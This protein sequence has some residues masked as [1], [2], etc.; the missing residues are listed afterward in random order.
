LIATNC[1]KSILSSASDSNSKNDSHTINIPAYRALWPGVPPP[2]Q[3]IRWHAN[4]VVVVQKT[5]S[6]PTITMADDSNR[7]DGQLDDASG[8]SPLIRY[9]QGDQIDE[10]KD[11]IKRALDNNSFNCQ[12]L[13]NLAKSGAEAASLVKELIHLNLVDQAELADRI[14]K[15]IVRD[16][17]YHADEHLKQYQKYTL[18]APQLATDI[19]KYKSKFFNLISL[20]KDVSTLA[21]KLLEISPRFESFKPNTPI[22]SSAIATDKKYLLNC[23]QRDTKSQM[24]EE[25]ATSEDLLAALIESSSS[26]DFLILSSSLDSISL[27]DMLVAS[28]ILITSHECFTLSHDIQGVAM[29]LRRAKFMIKN[30][31]A[32]KNQMELIIRLLT[33][34]GRY[35]EMKYVFDL[36]RDRNQFEILLSKG[37]EKT[38]ELRIAMFNYVKKNPEFYAL[39]TLNFSMFR[40]IA[41]SLEA[42]A[43]KRLDK[44]IDQSRRKSKRK[45]SSLM[46]GGIGSGA[47]QQ[48]RANRD[49]DG[50]EPFPSKASM[51]K[52]NSIGANLS[53]MVNGGGDGISPNNPSGSKG[54]AEPSNTKP[55]YSKDSL[56]MCLIEMVDASDCFAKAGCY[57]RSNNCESKAK[58]IALQLALLSSNA[59]VL[60][61][62]QSELNDTIVGFESFFDAY[63]VAEAYDYH[64]SW[65]QALFRNVVL[66]SHA[67]YLK[68]YCSTCEL[69]TALVMELVILLKQY[70]STTS[71]HHLSHD[72]IA[73]L[74]NSMKLIIAC[75]DDVE[76]RCKLY[77][78]LNLTDARD[79][80]LQNLSVKA[81]LKDLKLV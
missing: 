72:E 63:I 70:I 48:Q 24:S 58:L 51:T 42:S 21:R 45:K 37:V 39:V 30:I 32:P 17:E 6:R 2:E 71:S 35:N 80:L 61:L 26:D 40:E 33:S 22:L 75:L 38:P 57:K 68:D 47:K 29:V 8:S 49:N 25:D 53:N 52:S 12:E 19:G 46:I 18:N 59:N 74:S 73:K 15:D 79:E 34:I 50:Q 36:F 67:V 76:L 69:S 1:D 41:E 16:I 9:Y 11:Y 78:Q 13:I 23:S 44:L 10:M 66:R 55:L 65:R 56:N 43:L 81:H 31:L 27:K 4:L 5:N 62:Q 14:A 28:L 54:G 20:L 3:V 77:S 60:D 7:D 64:L